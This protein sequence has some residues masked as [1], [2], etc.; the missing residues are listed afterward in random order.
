[1]VETLAGP[2]WLAEN[3]ESADIGAGWGQWGCAVLTELMAAASVNAPV[4]R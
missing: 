2:N 3:T 4:G 1:M